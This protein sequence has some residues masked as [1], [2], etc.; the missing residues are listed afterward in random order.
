MDLDTTLAAAFD[1]EGHIS[2]GTLWAF[3]TTYP[4]LARLRDRKVLEDGVLSSLDTPID[5]QNQGFA[6]ADGWDGQKY[7]GLVLP[8]DSAGE[9]PATPPV[10]ETRS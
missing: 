7:T 8:T 4:Y 6:L 3:Y 1:R 5:W 2:L 9:Q 10:G